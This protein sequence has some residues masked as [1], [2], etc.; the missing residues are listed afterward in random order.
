MK[1]NSNFRFVLLFVLF[2]FTFEVEPQKI[3]MRPVASGYANATAAFVSEKSYKNSKYAYFSFRIDYNHK[4]YKAEKDLAYFLITTKSQYFPNS[5]LDKTVS[6]MFTNKDPMEL[7]YSDLENSKWERSNLKYKYKVNS[8]NNFS[9]YYYKIT[10]A[11]K[12][13]N[14]QYLILRIP[15]LNR[16]GSITVEN[17]RNFPPS[18]LEKTKKAQKHIARNLLESFNRIYLNFNK[19]LPRENNNTKFNHRRHIFEGYRNKFNFNFTYGYNSQNYNY[20]SI[21]VS[22]C[23][24]GRLLLGSILLLI[25]GILFI[26]YFLISRKSKTNVGIIKFEENRLPRYMSI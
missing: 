11:S 16:Q 26:A 12:D 19:S 15:I 22:S 21:S 3:I 9:K 24:K 2:A 1:A 14:N 6:Q 7:K 18:V 23:F 17:L 13:K 20:T 8:Y 5:A 25:W 10:R 4:Y